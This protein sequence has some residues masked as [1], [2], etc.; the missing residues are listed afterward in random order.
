MGVALNKDVKVFANNGWNG[1]KGWVVGGN[2][3][4]TFWFVQ[5]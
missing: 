4:N 3:G 5:Y 1:T 2:K